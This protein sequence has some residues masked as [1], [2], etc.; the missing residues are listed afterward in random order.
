LKRKKPEG[1]DAF[2]ARD[3]VEAAMVSY[4]IR[5]I[6]FNL[7]MTEQSALIREGLPKAVGAFFDTHPG[8]IE[9]ARAATPSNDLEG[10][11]DTLEAPLLAFCLDR[12]LPLMTERIYG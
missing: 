6:P 10:F 7:P 11:F 2:Y 1:R 8:A 9:N 4:M 5:H 3:S 12:G